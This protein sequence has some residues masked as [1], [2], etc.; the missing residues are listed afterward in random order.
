MSVE[1]I[2]DPDEDGEGFDL[3]PNQAWHGFCK[4]ARKDAYPAL[5]ALCS[6]LHPLAG[7]VADE[8]PAAQ[9]DKMASPECVAVIARLSELVLDADPEAVLLVE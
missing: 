1:L 2:F 5:Y 4:W 3:A 6:D 8:L 9:T 7:Q